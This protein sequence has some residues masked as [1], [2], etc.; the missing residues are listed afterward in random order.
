MPGAYDGAVDSGRAQRRYAVTFATA[1]SVMAPEMLQR[2]ESLCTALHTATILLL[3]RSRV[4]GFSL[5]MIVTSDL[6][7]EIERLRPSPAGSASHFTATRLSGT[8]VAKTLCPDAAGEP[9]CVVVDDALWSDACGEDLAAGIATLAHELAHCAI[10]RVREASGCVLLADGLTIGEVAAQEIVRATL[11]EYRA[12]LIED[13]FLQAMA[14][15]T[16]DG[17]AEPLRLHH[18]HGRGFADGLGAVLT[19]E[20][21]SGWPDRVQAFR[22]WQVPLEEM[23]PG[24]VRSTWEVF[25]TIAHAGSVARTA[26]APDPLDGEFASRPGVMLYLWEP[27][28]CLRQIADAFRPVCSASAQAKLEARAFSEG[29]DALLRMWG[30]LGLSFTRNDDGS[31]TIEVAE[32][33]RAG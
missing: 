21:S 19:G 33:L 28:Y 32:P 12:D 2:F 11:D 3:R 25:V 24:L 30:R 4:R 9:Y 20:V 15:A 18:V 7:A 26:G 14:T 16:E 8:V 29:V 5:R 10:E 6:A 23:W 27:W 13:L 1:R 22:D 17:E 31:T